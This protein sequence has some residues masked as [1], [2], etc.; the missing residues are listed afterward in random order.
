MLNGHEPTIVYLY[1]IAGVD[2][3]LA[4]EEQFSSATTLRLA[5]LESLPRDNTVGP[6]NTRSLTDVRQQVRERAPPNRRG[7]FLVETKPKNKH[8][9][10]CRQFMKPPGQS[11]GEFS[12]DYPRVS[13]VEGDERRYAHL[14]SP[15][16]DRLFAA[17][18]LQ[19]M[20]T[21]KILIRASS[22]YLYSLFWPDVIF[23]TAPNLDPGQEVGMAIKVQR[24]VNVDSEV[25]IVAGSNDHLQSSGIL[26]ALIDGT[27]PSSAIDSAMFREAT[28]QGYL[29]A[30]SWLCLA[31][32]TTAVCVR[33]GHPVGAG[34]I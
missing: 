28:G 27:T 23:L 34:K 19:E 6:L 9:K 25:V 13:S 16:G 14:E 15:K 2:W 26:N 17:F 22:D 4:E 29:R 5:D 31:T 30:V 21:G 8:H 24:A 32:R 1:R 10:M 20:K 33:H 11:A 18:D 12:R 7:K 3:L